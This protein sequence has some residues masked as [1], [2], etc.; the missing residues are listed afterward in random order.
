MPAARARVQARR[1]AQSPSL[2]IKPVSSAA[3]TNTGNNSQT[4][5]VNALDVPEIVTQPGNQAVTNG[6]TAQFSVTATGTQLTYQWRLAST[7]LSGATNATL[8][9]SGAQPKDVG[10]YTVEVRNSVGAVLSAPAT[11]TVY[12]PLIIT[13]QPVSQTVVRGANVTLSVSVT[14]SSPITYQWEFNGVDLRILRP[15]GHFRHA[16]ASIDADRYPISPCF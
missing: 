6:G 7:N 15:A 1:I 14:G 5:N 12:V 9:I 8:T 10:T 16:V 3:D 13:A 4:T 11:L 2:T